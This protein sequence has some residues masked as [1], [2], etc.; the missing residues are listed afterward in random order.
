MN[1]SAHIFRKDLR[2]LRWT[3]IAWLALVC[4]R[5][6]VATAG[7]DVALGGFGPQI[8]ISELSALLSLMYVLL[9]AF[10]VSSLVHDEPLVG[11]DAFW[12]TRPIAPDSLLGAKFI[13]AALFIIIV[14]VTADVVVAA[15]F[16]T[17]AHGIASTIVVAAFNHLVLVALLLAL[18]AMTPSL[19]RFVLATAGVVAA[20]A[21]LLVFVALMALFLT[22]EVSEGGGVALPDPTPAVVGGAMAVLAALAVVVYQYRT[23]RRGRALAIAAL[24]TVLVVLVPPRWTWSF[25][26]RPEAEVAEPP[27]D[28]STLAV[29][30]DGSAPRIGDVYT[31]R[32]RVSPKKQIAAHASVVGVAPEFTVRAIAARSQLELPDGVVLRSGRND[33]SAAVLSNSGSASG[34]DSAV[35]AALGGMRLLTRNREI[36]PAASEHWPV[37][38]RV[39]DRDFIRHRSETGRLTA[40]LDVAFD[41]I[42]PR[43]ALPLT[44]GATQDMGPF[45]VRVVQVIR[46][47]TGCTLLLRRSHVE[48]L[49]SPPTYI[50]FM[51][52][53]RNGTRGEL[54]GGDVRELSADGIGA[55]GFFLSRPRLGGRGFVLEQYEIEFPARSRPDGSSVDLDDAW[56]GGADLVVLEA[57]PAGVIRRTVAIDR[58]KMMP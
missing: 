32:R 3:L 35:E 39:E 54:A 27:R 8:G 22:E 9:L 24:G 25:A 29:S 12:I 26:A 1:Q 42:D 55:G 57:M 51:Y 14:P 10:L 48:T 7:A 46:H 17:D 20:L 11:R 19:A 49:F 36:D 31:F 28:T 50:P 37:L 44:D 5:T 43:A 38:L 30:L 41:R 4:A 45:T 56:I 40:N 16:G 34:R 6:F 47:A 21:A 15:V 52:V 23:R 13:F 58:F 53:L 2:R 18:A 33:A